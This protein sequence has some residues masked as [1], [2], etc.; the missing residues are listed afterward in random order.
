MRRD[1]FE[2]WVY[3]LL[4]KALHTLYK[5]PSI[6][7]HIDKLP[8]TLKTHIENPGSDWSSFDLRV[9]GKSSTW[10]LDSLNFNIYELRAF[11]WAFTTFQDSVGGPQCGEISKSQ[12]LT[13]GSAINRNFR[14][15][16]TGISCLHLSQI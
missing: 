3:Q 15:P 10:L 12:M 6:K 13:S 5:I 16:W 2:K 4:F 1:S 11:Q 14:G 8:K 7:S 9:I